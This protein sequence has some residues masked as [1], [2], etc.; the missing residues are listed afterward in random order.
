MVTSDYF[1]LLGFT[2]VFS[3]DS[4]ALE[5]AYFAMQRLFHPDRFIG[6]PALERQ[7]AMGRSVDINNAYE[8]LRNPLSRA[9]YLLHLQGI[10]VGTEHD[11]VRPAQA[12]LIETMEWREKI[13]E[14]TDF[15]ELDTTLETMITNSEQI[16]ADAFSSGAFE[17]MAQETL[18]LGYLLKSQEAVAFK[19]RRAAKGTM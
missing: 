8:T 10:A 5:A 9:Q 18:R 7:Q 13:D 16:I 19:L 3:L 14:A 1:S 2:P 11:T 4:K 6:K 15:A 12:L 17:R